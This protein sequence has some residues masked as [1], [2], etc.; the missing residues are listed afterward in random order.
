MAEAEEPVAEFQYTYTYDQFTVFFYGSQVFLSGKALPIGQ[1]CVDILNLDESVLDQI[2]QAV[3][4]MI[5]AARAV[6]TEKNR[7]RRSPRA[8]E[9]ERCL[10]SDLFFAGVPGP[11]DG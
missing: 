5:P 1:C 10:G 2:D 11:G 7:Q 6:L 3:K 4:E 8:G 9:A